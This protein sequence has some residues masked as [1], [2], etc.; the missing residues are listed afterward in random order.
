MLDVRPLLT[1]AEYKRTFDDELDW[2]LLTQLHSVVLQISNFCFRTKQIC[3]TVDVAV[4]GILFRI[5]DN[6]LDESIFVAGMIIPLG[7]W[8]LDAVA[9]F[10]QVKIRGVMESIREGLQ[11]RNEENALVG[12]DHVGVIDDSRVTPTFARRAL[13]AS[14]NHSMWFYPILL[15]TAV[16]LW[17][18]YD[19]K[20][21]GQ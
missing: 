14:F 13:Q 18:A 7:F 17:F 9:Y 21:I 19:M 16:G 12:L 10:Y 3:L 5:T 8:F 1:M 20:W 2:Q 15:L 4:I 11:K 6:R